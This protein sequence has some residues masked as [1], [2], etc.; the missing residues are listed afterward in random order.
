M[1]LN[2]SIRSDMDSVFLNEDE[3]A[4]QIVYFPRAGGQKTIKA[5]V[6][7]E[8]VGFYDAAGQVVLPAY[9]VTIANN[10]DV[11]IEF[12]DIDRGGDEV[13]LVD[14]FGEAE[15]KR[16]TVIHVQDRDFGGAITLA[17]K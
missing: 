10:S 1:T 11:G 3:F 16:L 4:E 12:D 17:L 9:V 2:D 14:K 13:E 5:I 6:D 7:R 15:R 8:P